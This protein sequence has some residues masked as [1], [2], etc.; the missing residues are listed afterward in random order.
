MLPWQHVTLL[1]KLIVCIVFDLEGYMSPHYNVLPEAVC[2]YL[3]MTSYGYQHTLKISTFDI[4]YFLSY[5][6]ER[7]EEEEEEHVQ[8]C[9]S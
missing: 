8:F 7:E 6:V 4:T 1:V 2:L 9:T 3:T 5:G